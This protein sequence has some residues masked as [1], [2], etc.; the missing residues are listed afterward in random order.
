MIRQ[1][2]GVRLSHSLARGIG[3]TDEDRLNVT[4]GRQYLKEHPEV[5]DEEWFQESAREEQDGAQS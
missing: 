4:N 2:R 1:S 3:I 5:L